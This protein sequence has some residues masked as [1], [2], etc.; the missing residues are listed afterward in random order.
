MSIQERFISKVIK[1]K[2]QLVEG[3]FSVT[4]RA[5]NELAQSLY[6]QDFPKT[7]TR[8]FTID[9]IN[10]VSEE[11]TYEL[12]T[13]R[14]FEETFQLQLE[15]DIDLESFRKISKYEEEQLE[16]DEDFI[17]HN[18]VPNTIEVIVEIGGQRHRVYGAKS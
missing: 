11:L 9:E 3:D 10:N 2:E 4:P 16:K 6:D 12:S 17:L 1:N 15:Y 8:S 13:H 14:Y 7:F 18:S 5:L